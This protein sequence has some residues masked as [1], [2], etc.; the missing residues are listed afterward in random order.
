MKQI[1]ETAVIEES[2]T[3]SAMVIPEKAEGTIKDMKLQYTVNLMADNGIETVIYDEGSFIKID[4][5]KSNCIEIHR[6]LKF[7]S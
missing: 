2:D 4:A 1:I 3:G 5:I 7:I 6:G